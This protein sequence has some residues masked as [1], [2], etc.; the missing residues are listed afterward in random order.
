MFLLRTKS[1][2]S[3]PAQLAEA[4]NASLREVFAVERDPVTVS[5]ISLPKVE[6]IAI[7]LDRAQLRPNPP[8]PPAVQGMPTAGL[9]LQFFAM[10]AANLSLGPLTADLHLAATDVRLD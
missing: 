1:F 4:M 7:N 2:P 3:T 5:A 8:T 9:E 6:R 10:D